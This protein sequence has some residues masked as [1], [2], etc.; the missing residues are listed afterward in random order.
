MALRFKVKYEDLEG[1]DIVI[2][3]PGKH[4]VCPTCEGHGKVVAPGIDDH[5]IT[6]EEFDEDPDFREDY[7]S[8]RYDV[9][10]SE[11]K[12]QNVVVVPALDLCSDA[13]KKLYEDYKAELTARADFEA[14][15]AWE[16]KM[17]C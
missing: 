8:G 3:I 15:C 16:R 5:G 17:G 12:G 7:F 11:C 14:E 9:Q 6:S 4:E 13:E 10:C 2:D 1:D